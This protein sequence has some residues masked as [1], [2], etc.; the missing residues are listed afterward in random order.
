MP[1]E[2]MLVEVKKLISMGK[3]K[4]YLTY[5][6]HVFYRT[7]IMKIS[8]LTYGTV[9]LLWRRNGKHPP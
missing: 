4:G 5:D 2:H 3:E 1:K 7:V 9:S 8:R 6:E